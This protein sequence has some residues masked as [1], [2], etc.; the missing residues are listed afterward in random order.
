MRGKCSGKKTPFFGLP[1]DMR[2]R[3][4]LCDDIRGMLGQAPLSPS[5]P[6]SDSG[7]CF[8][9]HC[10]NAIKLPDAVR[11][12]RLFD[13]LSRAD[14][15]SAD[16]MGIVW[17]ARLMGIK[18][19]ER[20]TGI[21][22]MTDL[23][24]RFAQ[25][26]VRVFLLGAR[27]DVLDRLQ[28]AL[29][30]RFPGLIIAGMHHGYE[31]DDAKLAKYVAKA[32]PD[33]LFVALPSPRKELFIDRFAQQTGCRF[34]MGVGG[35]FDVLADDIRRAPVFWQR[36]GLE[37]LWRICHQPRY[38]IP[39]YGYGLAGF[40]R[41]VVP[42]VLAFQMARLRGF[43]QKAAI[44]ALVIAMTAMAAIT[45]VSDGLAQASFSAPSD[46]KPPKASATWLEDALVGLKTPDDINQLIGQL[47]DHLFWHETGTDAVGQ[48]QAIETDW[49][50]VESR[51][52]ALLRLFDLVLGNGV[53]G[54]LVETVL[55]GLVLQLIDLH[56]DPGR[57]TDI[58]QNNA[59][60]NAPGLAQ[61]L[62]ESSK[63]NP[64]ILAGEQTS[65]TG[66]TGD[67]HATQFAAVSMP[68]EIRFAR[69]YSLLFVGGLRNPSP[70]TVW[71]VEDYEEPDGIAELEDAS[72]R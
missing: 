30:K 26:G 59:L 15:L 42:K 52:L 14:C 13:A 66:E 58:V 25:D 46:P 47:V 10:L 38:M 20:V 61:R 57:F 62:F 29:P 21:D 44:W 70:D 31:M 54:F 64:L 17:A 7:N 18:V 45:P 71:G 36:A 9:H 16:G 49:G 23:L 8:R 33:A 41:L 53:S 35:A 32:R 6:L 11:N 67:T 48:D 50:D 27:R 51:F 69:Q 37:F 56:P 1:L 40:A 43:A 55:G 4:E 5:P 3:S 12:K 19:P 28:V 22:L 2:R 39:R 63:A 34:A 65:F 60:G 24:A 72:P 68:P